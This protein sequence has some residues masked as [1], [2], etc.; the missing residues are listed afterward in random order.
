ML[1][2]PNK[3]FLFFRYFFPRYIYIWVYLI[4]PN[5]EINLLERVL[6][7]IALPVLSKL[8]RGRNNGK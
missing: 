4:I 3:Y 8:D 2:L 6:I 7:V 1:L 5:V